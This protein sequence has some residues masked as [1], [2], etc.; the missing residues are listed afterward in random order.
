MAEGEKFSLA[1]FASSFFTGIHWVKAISFALSIFA[2]VAVGYGVYR[3][4][5]KPQPT[6]TQNIEAQP[7][8][9]VTV[10][11]IYERKKTMIFFIEPGV[12]QRNNSDM[13]TYIRGGIRFEF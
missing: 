7:G 11:H 1:K 8:S 10:Q 12:E 2:L 13:G 9:N 6:N 4:Y 3:T 5:F